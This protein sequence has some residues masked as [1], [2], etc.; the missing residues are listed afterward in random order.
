MIDQ[1]ERLE[2]LNV[3]LKESEQKSK[4]SSFQLNEY[5]NEQKVY[6]RKI[7]EMQ[8]QFDS[9]YKLL[10]EREQ[11]NKILLSQLN[12]LRKI[13]KHNAVPPMDNE[14][15]KHLEKIKNEDSD[16]YSKD[17]HENDID[18][19]S[20]NLQMEDKIHKTLEDTN[21]QIYNKEAYGNSNLTAEDD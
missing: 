6:Q 12:S 2:Y 5:K 20:T 11:E 4:I 10:K 9:V 18:K 17:S 14:I 16:L 3:Q 8:G 7:N 19:N 13:V 1:Q 15:V 21:N